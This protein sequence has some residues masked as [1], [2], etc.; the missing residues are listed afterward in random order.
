VPNTRGPL[1]PCPL[2]LLLIAKAP[3]VQGE[4]LSIAHSTLRLI[5]T[6]AINFVVAS[7]VLAEAPRGSFPFGTE[8]SCVSDH[9]FSLEQC[10]NAAANAQAE[11]DEK[12]P[13]YA[14]RDQCEVV[15]GVGHCSVG[16]AG[17]RGYS[18]NA[19]GVYFTPRQTG[20]RITVRSEN[21]MT[22][23]PFSSNPLLSF[24]PRTILRMQTSRNPHVR[25]EAEEA[26]KARSASSGGEYGVSSPG[27]GLGDSLPPPYPSDPNFDCASVIEPKKGEDPATG[28]YPMGPAHARHQ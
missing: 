14:K 17:T 28:C 16:F 5:I 7:S 3:H 4:I 20:F 24:R 23:L 21:D 9:R 12:T 15:F 25:E 11:F 1:A 22:V 26:F 13:R 10:R 2:A 18:G 8:Q 6:S 27:T 19:A